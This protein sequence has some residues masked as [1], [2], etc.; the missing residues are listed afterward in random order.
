MQWPRM[1]E[2]TATPLRKQ[3]VI[4]GVTWDTTWDRGMRLEAL[5]RT[6]GLISRVNSSVVSIFP[7]IEYHSSFPS[8]LFAQESK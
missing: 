3:H 5:C 6:D 1:P 8:S 7:I 2:H 4:G